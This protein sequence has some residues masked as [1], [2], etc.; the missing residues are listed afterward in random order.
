MGNVPDVR[1]F[2]CVGRN[3]QSVLNRRSLTQTY[4]SERLGVSRQ[5]MH[6]ILHGKKQI[7]VWELYQIAKILQISTDSCLQGLEK[8][9]G[10]PNLSDDIQIKRQN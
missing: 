9:G 2:Q 1:I 8:L 4:L 10:A 5:V 7:N 3:I 6:K